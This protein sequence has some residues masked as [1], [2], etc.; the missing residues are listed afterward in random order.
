MG[1]NILGCAS[2]TIETGT[3]SI[4]MTRSVH[5]TAFALAL[6]IS[7]NAQAANPVTEI[8]AEDIPKGTLGLGFGW[9]W[10]DSPF[11]GIDHVGSLDNDNDSEY[12]LLPPVR[13]R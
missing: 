1:L 7:I 8:L 10:G 12:D 9:R 11:K 5:L 13:H 3:R 6:F 4:H 2:H